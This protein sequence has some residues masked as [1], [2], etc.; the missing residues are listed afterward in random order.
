MSSNS[1]G[2]KTKST[3]DE[4]IVSNHTSQIEDFEDVEEAH[5]AGNVYESVKE[6]IEGA[7]A[8]DVM[9][10]KEGTEDVVAAFEGITVGKVVHNVKPSLNTSC[11]VNWKDTGKM[12]KHVQVKISK[13]KMEKKLSLHKKE[14]LECCQ[15]RKKFCRKNSLS[16]HIKKMHDQVKPHQCS[17]PGCTEKFGLKLDLKKHMMKVHNF[18]KPYSCIEQNCDEKFVELGF[19][20]S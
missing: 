14:N 16:N 8:D 15:C 7:E 5:K 3:H 19:L 4:S 9:N 20:S 13:F 11:K 10:M 18:E 17:Q 6:Y 1:F 12:N 2:F